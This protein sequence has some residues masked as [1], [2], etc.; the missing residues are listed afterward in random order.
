VVPQAPRREG[1]ECGEG[2]S[3]LH[4]RKGLEAVSPPQKI[5]RIFLKI[6]YFDVF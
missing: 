4:W 1:V 5:F 3:P 2:V 6:P